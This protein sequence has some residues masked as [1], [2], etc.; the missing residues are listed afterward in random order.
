MGMD[1]DGLRVQHAGLDQAAQDMYAKVKEIDDRLN[2]LES[3]LAG[4]R[5]SWAGNQREAYDAAKAKWDWALEQMKALLDE[6]SRTV[7]HSNSEYA[8]ADA[9][10]AQAF[11][12]RV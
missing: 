9:R 1:L 12:I 2:R 6:T 3:E 5:A 8:A 11:D 7:H 10:G 4:L